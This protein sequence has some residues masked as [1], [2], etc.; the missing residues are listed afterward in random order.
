LIIKC[1]LQ[2]AAVSRDEISFETLAPEVGVSP[3]LLR[4]YFG[5]RREVF[6]AAVD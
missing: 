5:T 6:R 3:A 2:A 1:F 4:H